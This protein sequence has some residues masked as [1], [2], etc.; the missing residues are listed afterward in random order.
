MKLPAF[1]QPRILRQALRAVLSPP[2]TTKFP[3]EPLVLVEGFRG[4][5]RFDE[6]GCIG[7]GACAEVCPAKCIEVIDDA[8]ASP[9]MRRLV[10]HLDGCIWCGQCARYCPT[11]RG[12]TMSRE[13]DCA[14]FTLGEHDEHV[15]KELALCDL[16]GEPIAPLDQLRWLANRLGPIAFAN[17]TLLGVVAG[18][19]GVMDRGTGNRDAGIRRSDRSALQCP[20][21]RRKTAFAV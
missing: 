11:Q 10:Q 18:D 7:C 21:C 14:H 3:A 8:S 15:S 20:R 13:F 12:I 9:P 2:F 19:L 1:L 17:P 5:P 16:C 6:A 4:R